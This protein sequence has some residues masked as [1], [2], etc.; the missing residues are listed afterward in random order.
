MSI[1][2]TKN[3]IELILKCSFSEAD[4]VK[5]LW[6]GDDAF[7]SLHNAL[8][9]AERCI[10][11]EF[12]IFRNDETGSALADILIQKSLNGIDVRVIYDHFGSIGTPRSFWK[13]MSD[14]GIK[15]RSSYPFSWRAPLDYFRR[16]HKKLI[17]I[18]KHT[19]FLGGLNIANEYSGFHLRRKG[20]SWRD[21]G[22]M[23]HGPVVMMLNDIFMKTWRSRKKEQTN[24]HN[25][26]HKCNNII[27]AEK[28]SYDLKTTETMKPAIPI[29]ASSSS[30]RRRFR[31]LLR[32]SISSAEKEILLTTAYF[33]PGRLLKKYL[34]A[35]AAR[36]VSVR[37]LLPMQSDL[38]FVD[39]AG[40]AS[41]EEL[42]KAGVN[43]HLYKGDVLHAKTY[44]FDRKWSI[45]GSANL[46]SMSLRYNDEGNIGIFDEGFGSKMAKMFE[47]DM[48]ESQ[49]LSLDEWIRRGAYS[50]LLEK[51]F[52]L[53]RRR[54]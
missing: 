32:K 16:D 41:Y 50:K 27:T 52:H 47:H 48:R 29:F 39:Y 46:D 43:I 2:I 9:I 33:T 34:K 36:G 19:A 13:K 17:L 38:P 18:D 6:K 45:I 31:T 12:Y 51:F 10:C 44:V 37:L 42:L 54:L 35:A 24:D 49:L 28:I 20:R 53:F 3:Q 22:I 26:S 5:L 4:I 25:A 23:I 40:R 14:A 11:L 7:S 1:G 8:N 30:G 15:V 21:T